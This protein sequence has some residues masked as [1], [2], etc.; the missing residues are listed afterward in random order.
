MKTLSLLMLACISTMSQ[1]LIAADAAPFD[2]NWNVDLSCPNDAKSGALGYDFHFSAQISKGML[3]GQR[4]VEKEP[5][6]LQI[7]GLVHED[8]SAL[9]MVNGLTGKPAYTLDH[10]NSGT[11]YH[12]P[13][14]AQFDGNTGN[15]QRVGDR[16]CHFVFNKQ[17][18]N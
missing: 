13:V 9:L 16:H 5:T 17:I 2:G 15:G 12:Y 8:G 11:P 6:W 18:T 1:S 4:G 7:S 14:Q 3:L 10:E